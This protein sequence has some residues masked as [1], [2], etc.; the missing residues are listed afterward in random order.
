MWVNHYIP[1][2]L[3]QVYLKLTN[4]NW[5]ILT[6]NSYKSKAAIVFT[7]RWY[8]K[9][10]KE[11]LTQVQMFQRGFKKPSNNFILSMCV[12][13]FMVTLIIAPHF[14]A[15]AVMGKFNWIILHS[16]V[17]GTLM[18]LFG[19]LMIVFTNHSITI[20]LISIFVDYMVC[21]KQKHMIFS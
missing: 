3:F 21:Q 4:L 1:H 8:F 11:N 19:T 14:I 17:F 9:Y 15:S 6:F 7:N 10:L 20:H 12:T 18:I 2:I 13:D 5:L 16:S